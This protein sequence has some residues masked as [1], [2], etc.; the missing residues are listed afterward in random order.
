M[1]ITYPLSLPSTGFKSLEIVPRT[2]VGFN[3]SQWTGQ[4]QVFPWPG[5]WWVLNVELPRMKPVTAALWSAFF[6]A[7][8]S[9]EGTFYVGPSV[10]KTTGGTA[11]GAWTVGAG[12][13]AN[14]TTLPT[15]GGTGVLAKG[16]FIQV[17]ATTAARL[18]QVTQVN[19][20]SV[21]VFPRLRSAYANGTTIIFTNPVGLFCMPQIPSEAYDAGKI[22]HGF[23]FTALEVL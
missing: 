10:R 5:Q 3:A 22:C 16:D 20:G 8:N 1:A 21:D 11:A 7:L 2:I 23:N 6:L 17:G 13:V 12:A 4:Q 19:V 9:Y 18:H 14:S 15:A